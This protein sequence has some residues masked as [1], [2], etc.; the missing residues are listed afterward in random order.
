[1]DAKVI[2]TIDG[3]GDPLAFR[4][5]DGRVRSPLFGSGRD[6]VKVEARQLAGH[7]KKRW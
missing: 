3:F 5:R 2:D 4:L 7:K 1:M 6:V